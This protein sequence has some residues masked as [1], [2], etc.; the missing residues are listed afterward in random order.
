MKRFYIKGVTRV[1]LLS[2]TICLLAYLF[3]KTAFIA[4]AISTGLLAL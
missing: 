3:F 4:A 1:L 2:G